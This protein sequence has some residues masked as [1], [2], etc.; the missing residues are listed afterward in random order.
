MMDILPTRNDRNASPSGLN[1]LQL[2]SSHGLLAG[3]PPPPQSGS[4]KV[5]MSALTPVRAMERAKRAVK[6]MFKFSGLLATLKT[7]RR[8]ICDMGFL[9]RNH[10]I[11]SYK[12][13]TGPLIIPIYQKFKFRVFCP[14]TFGRFLSEFK[15]TLAYTNFSQNSARTP[16]LAFKFCK[17]QITYPTLIFFY[18]HLYIRLHP[19]GD[20][21]H[22]G[23]ESHCTQCNHYTINPC[24]D[25]DQ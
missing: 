11:I 13:T 14:D 6:R 21:E 3:P 24:P 12:A 15:F 7:R 5:T 23:G 16:D 8:S 22:W 20:S 17:P 2:V 9:M 4:L 10:L 1:R 25:K 18:R 19:P